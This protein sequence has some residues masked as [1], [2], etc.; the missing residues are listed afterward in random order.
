[1]PAA[2]AARRRSRSQPPS[3]GASAMTGLATALVPSRYRRRALARPALLAAPAFPLTAALLSVVNRSRLQEWGW[4]PLDHSG[5]PWPSSLSLLPGGWLQTL[6]FAGTGVS[7]V[8]LAA[9]LPR[10]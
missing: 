6:S 9:A 10:G 7:L 2:S 4:T 5:V 8:L 3:E 1:M